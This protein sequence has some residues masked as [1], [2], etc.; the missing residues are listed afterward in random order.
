MTDE[1]VMRF[2]DD[3]WTVPKKFADTLVGKA[4]I[5]GNTRRRDEECVEVIVIQHFLPISSER[6]SVFIQ[7]YKLSNIT[8]LF[9]AI[10]YENLAMA[11]T[12]NIRSLWAILRDMMEYELIFENNHGDIPQMRYNILYLLIKMKYVMNR[13]F[14]AKFDHFLSFRDN[15]CSLEGYPYNLTIKIYEKDQLKFTLNLHSKKK[16]EISI[17]LLESDTLTYEIFDQIRNR[18]ID[19]PEIYTGSSPI[20]LKRAS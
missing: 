9:L 1:L 2:L 15:D 6:L 5:E 8:K 3:E 13:T 16:D 14:G 20:L 4:I 17:V 7:I 19:Y 10:G 12:G 11:F 18:I